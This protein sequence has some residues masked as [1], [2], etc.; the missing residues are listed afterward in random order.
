[1]AILL[2]FRWW[3][4]YF[5]YFFYLKDQQNLSIKGTAIVCGV[6]VSV[7]IISVVV[8]LYFYDASYDGQSY[9]LEA[10]IQLAQGWNPFYKKLPNT[11]SYAIWVTHFPKASWI[12]ASIMYIITGSIESGKAFNLILIFATYSLCVKALFCLKKLKHSLVFLLAALIAFDPINLNSCL[13]FLCR[14]ASC[15]VDELLSACFVIYFYK[16]DL[17]A[18]WMIGMITMI[19]VNLKFPTVGYV[20]IYFL[21]FIII[22]LIENK[23]ALIKPIFT[24]G[25]TCGLVAI[26][27]VGFNPYIKNTIEHGHP[28][29][30]V[31]GNKKID[32]LKYFYP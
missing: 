20:P 1:M 9:H 24:V 15:L 8:S 23:K 11:I 27:F 21:G 4:H 16:R 5:H 26:T 3:Q 31:A 29:H 12:N 22:A 2:L 28:F 17:L 30:P 7:V 19:V 13:S 25:V 10:I 32:I 6:Y 18:L 14:W